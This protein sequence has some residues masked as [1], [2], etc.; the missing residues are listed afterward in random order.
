M[1]LIALI[2]A[3]LIFGFCVVAH[4]LLNEYIKYKHYE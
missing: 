2:V 1:I 3:A 4:I